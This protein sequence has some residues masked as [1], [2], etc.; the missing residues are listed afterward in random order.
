MSAVT[1]PGM[2]ATP[3]LPAPTC[4]ATTG[5]HSAFYTL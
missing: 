5:G 4:K 1:A 3:M 2:T